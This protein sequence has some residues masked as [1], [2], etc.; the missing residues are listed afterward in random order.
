MIKFGPNYSSPYPNFA[1][2]VVCSE[3]SA[4]WYPL[5]EASLSLLHTE[6]RCVNNTSNCITF[7]LFSCYDKQ[8]TH[9]YSFVSV[10]QNERELHKWTVDVK[11]PNKRA[12]G[13][14]DAEIKVGLFSFIGTK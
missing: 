3:F 1:E 12:K 2:H 7:I 5:H 13:C 8:T 6:K 10:P 14:K 9:G 4:F 11:E